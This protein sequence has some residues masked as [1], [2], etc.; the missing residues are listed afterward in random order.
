MKQ[1]FLIS[2]RK[3]MVIADACSPKE[4]DSGKIIMIVEEKELI[5]I[6][7]KEMQHILSWG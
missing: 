7:L 1:Y 2:Q 3:G 4:D 5:K 6:S